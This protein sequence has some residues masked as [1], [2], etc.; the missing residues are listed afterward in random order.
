M[1]Q[2]LSSLINNGGTDLER[3]LYTF[4]QIQRI[5]FFTITRLNLTEWV[6]K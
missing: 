3:T 6:A 2:L 4:K 1:K 5:T